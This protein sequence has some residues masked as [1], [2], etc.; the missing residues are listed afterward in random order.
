MA[1]LTGIAVHSGFRLCET[2]STA[3]TGFKTI[4][5]V[6]TYWQVF[7]L[8]WHAVCYF[9]LNYGETIKSRFQAPS[10]GCGAGDHKQPASTY[11][12]LAGFRF[13]HS[14]Q[15]CPF[16]PIFHIAVGMI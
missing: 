12:G 9:H 14:K 16:Q 7:I 1:E 11:T 15:I 13:A 3:D 4:T 2:S 8:P 6:T 10:K 5:L